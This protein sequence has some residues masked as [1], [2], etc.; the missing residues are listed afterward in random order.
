MFSRYKFTKFIHLSFSYT[1][2]SAPFPQN[3]RGYPLVRIETL[4]GYILYKNTRE[5]M[6]QERLTFDIFFLSYGF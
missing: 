3:N 6:I 4:D 5:N 2:F 1:F